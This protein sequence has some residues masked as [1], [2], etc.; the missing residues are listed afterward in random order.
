MRV[1]LAAT[2]CTARARGNVH[3]DTIA[4]GLLFLLQVTTLAIIEF[5]GKMRSGSL[6]GGLA[7][8]TGLARQSDAPSLSGASEIRQ[9]VAVDAVSTAKQC[10]PRTAA[11]LDPNGS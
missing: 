1:A 11:N 6:S 4:C 8:A 2:Q 7:Q 3:L 5:A 10:R 9:A